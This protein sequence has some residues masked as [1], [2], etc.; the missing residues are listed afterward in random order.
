MS[1]GGI[2]DGGNRIK[3]VPRMKGQGYKDEDVASRLA[4]L[5]EETDCRLAHVSACAIP[6]EQMRGNIENPIGSIQMPLGVAGPLLIH[7]DHAR[8]IFYAP[9]ATTEGALVRSYERGMVTISR[10]GGAEV[11]LFR[12]ENQISPSFFF[13]TLGEA[14]GFVDRLDSLFEDLKRVAESTTHHGKLLRVTTNPVGRRVMATFYYD[15]GDAQGMNMI[16]KATDA[17]C[18]W[19]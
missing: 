12:N 16:V 3:L 13:E 7:G 14:A 17:A 2:I 8:G 11:R 4:W 19:K 15:T 5:E 10:S 9:L 1:E 18:N 6:Y